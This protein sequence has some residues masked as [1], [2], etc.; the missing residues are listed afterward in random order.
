MLL[1]DE[2][3]NPFKGSG[4]EKQDRHKLNKKPTNLALIDER[5]RF[6]FVAFRK[7]PQRVMKEANSN[8]MPQLAK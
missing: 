6:N 1:N 3:N 2:L 7:E 5:W 4:S 8:L